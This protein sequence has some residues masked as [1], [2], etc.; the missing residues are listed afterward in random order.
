MHEK[1]NS[2]KYNNLQETGGYLHEKR[3]KNTD[4]D[5]DNLYTLKKRK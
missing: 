3:S 1:S 5:E 4:K 2:S